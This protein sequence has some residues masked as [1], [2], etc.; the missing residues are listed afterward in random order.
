MTAAAIV[1]GLPLLAVLLIM[2]VV[3]WREWRWRRRRP[4]LDSEWG[5]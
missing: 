3:A 1:F 2:V 5:Q 4:R